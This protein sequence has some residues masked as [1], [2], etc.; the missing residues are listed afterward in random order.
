MAMEFVRDLIALAG[1]GLVGTGCWW[2]C[3]PAALIVVGAVL[4]IGLL[5]GSARRGGKP[6]DS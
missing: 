4:L 2:L 3:P 1:I 6:N 5:L